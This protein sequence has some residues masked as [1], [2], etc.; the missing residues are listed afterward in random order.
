MCNTENIRKQNIKY[1]TQN[2]MMEMFY[3][4]AWSEGNACTAEPNLEVLR[5]INCLL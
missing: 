5:L 1:Y 2:I 3:I 4:I